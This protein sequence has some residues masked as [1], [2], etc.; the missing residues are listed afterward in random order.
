MRFG[1]SCGVGRGSQLGRAPFV[2][3]TYRVTL[4]LAA[5]WQPTV[6]LLRA[7]GRV[8]NPWSAV[9]KATLVMPQMSYAAC[10]Q[11]RLPGCDHQELWDLYTAA[12]EA[13]GNGTQVIPHH[14]TDGY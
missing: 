11:Y 8:S 12:E 2:I 6:A 1:M 14:G 9:P 7:A 5:H 3:G 13:H 10:G 4:L